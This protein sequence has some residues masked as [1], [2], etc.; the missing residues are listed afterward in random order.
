MGY[1]LN[2]KSALGY[3]R[4]RGK[5]ELVTFSG[6]TVVFKKNQPYEANVLARQ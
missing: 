6:G 2:I 5:L 3:P 4:R 1:Q